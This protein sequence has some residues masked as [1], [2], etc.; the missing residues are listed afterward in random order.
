LLDYKSGKMAQKTKIETTLPPLE[1]K[2]YEFLFTQLLEG[3]FHGWHQARIAKFFHLLGDRGQSE[4][5]VDWLQ[6]YEER[7]AIA[8]QSNQQMAV[9]MI[10][11]GDAIDIYNDPKIN[12]IGSTAREIGQKCLNLNTGSSVWEYEG[13]DTEDRSSDSIEEEQTVTLEQL[14]AMLQQDSN[15]VGQMAQQLGLETENP[16]AI[17]EFLQQQIPQTPSTETTLEGTPEAIPEIAP[18]TAEDWFILGL[19]QA[20]G[21]NMQGAIASWDKALE[22]DSELSSAWH[23]RGSALGYL[24]RFNEAVASFDRAIAIN[25]EDFQAWND[26]GLAL[27]NLQ[28]W[29]EAIAS[30]DKAIEI[31]P[32]CFQA[33]YN[34]GCLLENTGKTTEA[35]ESYQKV[36]ELQPDF[37]PAQT[38]LSSLQNNIEADD[39][40]E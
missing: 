21:S 30:W 17:I 35:I 12:K 38:R 25:S 2:D 24:G 33:W 26:R 4:L 27:F 23:N 31:E 36:I 40:Q 15:L 22:L 6:R 3:V 16:Q 7:F 28:N 1:D 37:E 34:R 11:L 13:P 10:R 9:Q 5:W 8:T 18:E 29:D 39:R 14:F 19:K 20:E 32:T